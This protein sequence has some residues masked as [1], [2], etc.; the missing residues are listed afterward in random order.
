MLKSP[1]KLCEAE[2]SAVKVPDKSRLLETEAVVV[3]NA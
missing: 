2:E 3:F 1:A